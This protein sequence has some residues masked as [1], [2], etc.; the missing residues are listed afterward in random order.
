MNQAYHPEH[1]QAGATLEELL[2]HPEHPLRHSGS[3]VLRG[4]EPEGGSVALG[5]AAHELIL[6]HRY[7]KVLCNLAQLQLLNIN[8][9]TDIL[10]QALS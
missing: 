9:I 8:K 4:H 10:S 3:D 5:A 1:L 7:S 6:L 2:H